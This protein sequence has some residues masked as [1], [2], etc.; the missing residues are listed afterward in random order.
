M[1]A[2]MLD[3]ARANAAEAGA[4]NVSSFGAILR[5]SVPDGSV[6]VI[7]SNCVINLSGNRDAVLRELPRAAAGGRFG[8]SDILAEDHLTEAERPGA[9]A[10]IGC[11]AGALSFAEYQDC[12]ARAGFTSI[13]ITA[14]HQVTNGMHSAIVRAV[15]P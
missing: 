11:I 8:V 2:E 12:L 13:S 7:I 3:L 9:A 14:T 10:T 15:R 6:D 4:V 1:T 5:H